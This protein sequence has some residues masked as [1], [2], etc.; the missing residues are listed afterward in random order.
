M[1]VQAAYF[2]ILAVYGFFKFRLPGGR[3]TRQ[4]RYVAFAGLALAL[5]T[6]IPFGPD[7]DP[8]R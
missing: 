8:S 7:F 6:F 1:A 2:G 3:V 5:A 4:S